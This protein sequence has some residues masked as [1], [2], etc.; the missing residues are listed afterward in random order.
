LSIACIYETRQPNE[1]ETGQLQAKPK[2]IFT[3]LLLLFFQILK[4]QYVA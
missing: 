4:L 1:S 2:P 3:S